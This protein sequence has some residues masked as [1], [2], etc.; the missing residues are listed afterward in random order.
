MKRPADMDMDH[1][2]PSPPPTDAQS[3][4][5]NESVCQGL[6]LKRSHFD[7]IPE[8]RR[9]ACTHREHVTAQNSYHLQEAQLTYL[10]HRVQEPE[11]I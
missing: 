9:D 5:G 7:T 2:I 11:E 8:E 1:S 10:R 3:P 6:P 4:D